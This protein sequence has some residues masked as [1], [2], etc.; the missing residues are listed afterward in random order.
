M[1]LKNA[2]QALPAEIAGL[3]LKY[4]LLVNRVNPLLSKPVLRSSVNAL[5]LGAYAIAP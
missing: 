4:Q 5:D 1:A 3:T 2:G